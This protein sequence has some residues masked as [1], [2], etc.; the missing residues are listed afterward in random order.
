M[1]IY[2]RHHNIFHT[3]YRLW[4]Y[5]KFRKSDFSKNTTSENKTTTWI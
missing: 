3:F 1:T 5:W 4:G 2:F